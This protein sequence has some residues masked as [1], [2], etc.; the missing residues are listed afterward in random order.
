MGITATFA[1][2]LPYAA[3]AETFHCGNEDVPCLILAINSANS[4]TQEKSRITLESGGTYTLTS[5]DNNT[6]GPNGL[7]SI[8]GDLTIRVKG[9]GTATLTRAADA[10]TPA[11]RLLHVAATG[12]LTLRELIIS[13]G[14]IVGQAQG[15]GLLNGGGELTLN[16]IT[17]S[18]NFASDGVAGLASSGVATIKESSFI[19]NFSSNG[20]GG[21][22]NS[23]QM[24]VLD[25]TINQNNGLGVGGLI[26]SGTL[27]IFRSLIIGNLGFFEVGGL[28]VVGGS[29]RI[30]ETTFAG[31]GGE[32]IG[33]LRV[34]PFRDVQATVVVTESAFDNN[35]PAAVVVSGPASLEVINTTFS[36]NTLPV[37]VNNDGGTLVLTNATFGENTR[38]DPF[39]SA[40]DPTILVSG[41]ANALQAAA[42]TILQ[43]TILAH[44]ADDRV[45]QDCRGPVI[46]RGNNI[47]GDPTGCTI[48]LQPGDLT[49]DPGLDL[50]TDD[51]KPGHVYFTLLPTSPAIG[52]GNPDVCPSDD[53][54]DRLRKGR[55]DIGAIQFRRVP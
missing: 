33:A 10:N 44:D 35:G 38:V 12:H 1:V 46:S 30:S 13:N 24:T 15:G 54:L 14:R 42:T 50:F 51:G 6:D 36:R 19:G 41:T 43:N 37:L 7:P 9:K 5:V 8:T 47:I 22:S 29:V 21:V 28:S 55:C 39:P 48:T 20:P 26:N 25:S 17:V 34:E 32:G 40:P 45:N 49:G 31:N 11:F 23:G 52:A 53:Q 18:R 2:I 4:L 27:T 16:R 3:E